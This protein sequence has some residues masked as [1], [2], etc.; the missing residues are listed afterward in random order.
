MALKKIRKTVQM[1]KREIYPTTY[2]K[3]IGI[4]TTA[5]EG[6]KANLNYAIKANN[7][8]ETRAKQTTDRS[9]DRTNFMVKLYKYFNEDFGFTLDEV[10]KTITI[11]TEALYLKDKN[12]T[13]YGPLYPSDTAKTLK[14]Y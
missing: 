4:V 1:C 13:P 3:L 11:L 6:T 12:G 2:K 9:S 8:L 14:N 5:I 7:P 10:K